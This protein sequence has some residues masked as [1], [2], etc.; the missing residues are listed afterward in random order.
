M[1]TTF[2]QN[3]SSYIHRKWETIIKITK[4]NH[5]YQQNIPKY[6]ILSVRFRAGILPLWINNPSMDRFAFIN[7]RNIMLDPKYAT[8]R[9]QFLWCESDSLLHTA[10]FKMNN[11]Y[12]MQINTWIIR[13]RWVRVRA[14]SKSIRRTPISFRCTWENI[15]VRWFVHNVSNFRW[16]V[17]TCFT[18][19]Y[20]CS[21]TFSF[22]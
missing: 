9:F 4:I 3:K 1:Q 12:N 20:I 15:D 16:K 8:V 11:F 6:L 2:L 18:D 19:W 5:D 17:G 22:D 10:L 14:R 7:F 21:P 13:Y